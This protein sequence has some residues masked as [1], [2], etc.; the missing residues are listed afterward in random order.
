MELC[1]GSEDDDDED[2]D[3]LV[4]VWAVEF[5]FDANPPVEDCANTPL[6]FTPFDPDP[7]DP[8]LN[9]DP[10]KDDPP[11]D[12]PNDDPLEGPDGCRTREVGHRTAP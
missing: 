4:P 9:P 1:E 6:L 10:L 3:A 11:G 5:K 7:L 2:A 8:E 12:E